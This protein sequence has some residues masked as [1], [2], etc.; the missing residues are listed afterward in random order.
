MLRGFLATTVQP[1]PP[2][3]EG[4]VVAGEAPIIGELNPSEA[5]GVVGGPP[6]PVGSLVLDIFLVTNY[7]ITDTTCA[8]L[9]LVDLLCAEHRWQQSTEGYCRVSNSPLSVTE[10]FVKA[11][12]QPLR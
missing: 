1:P 12:I 9:E 5:A 2:V 6:V 8:P 11:A 7:P 3:A 10:S 4:G